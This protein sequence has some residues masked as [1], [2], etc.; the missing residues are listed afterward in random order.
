MWQRGFSLCSILIVAACVI[1]KNK[2]IKPY[3]LKVHSPI[4]HR[5][6]QKLVSNQI[7][8]GSVASD[9]ALKYAKKSKWLGKACALFQVSL[10]LAKLSQVFEFDMHPILHAP[11]PNIFWALHGHEIL[12][13][14]NIKTPNKIK[15]FLLA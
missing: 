15:H 5:I 14:R 13:R 3:H 8:K 9:P 2:K 4:R 12:E 11:R 10:S 6:S 1:S 7:Q